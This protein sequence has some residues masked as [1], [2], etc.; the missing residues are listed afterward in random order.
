VDDEYCRAKWRAD[1]MSKWW[2]RFFLLILILAFVGQIAI[3]F[4]PTFPELLRSA[5]LIVLLLCTFY[6]LSFH[7]IPSLLGALLPKAGPAPSVAENAYRYSA[8]RYGIGYGWL[9]VQCTIHPDGSA[10][11]Q[12]KVE[13]EGHSEISELDTFLLIPEKP[14]PGE[15][16]DIDFVQVR[17]LS[18]G[19]NVSLIHIPEQEGK[20][21]ALIAISPQLGEGQSVIYEMIEKLPPRLYAINFTKEELAKRKSPYDY[22]GWNINRPT[23]RL[24][25]RVYFPED[26]KPDV[27]VLEVRYASAAPGIP[28][29]SFQY[30]EQGRLEKP[31]LVGP[32]GGRYFLKLDVDYPMIGLVYILR[33]QPLVKDLI[34][35]S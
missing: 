23:R 16:W 19:Y 22:F 6:F 9:E 11:V 8:E 18:P 10:E 17:S 5:L 13:V 3:L 31:S 26:V 29:E 4:L 14:P 21:S 1:G 33:W 32:E 15:K 34:G 20:L 28:S 7:V 2:D 12:R 27:Y 24:S 25:L 30:K 35:N